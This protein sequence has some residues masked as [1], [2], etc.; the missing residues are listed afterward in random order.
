MT[1]IPADVWRREM[2]DARAALRWRF[3]DL[4]CLR[5]C[6]DR[7]LVRMW[8]DATLVPGV[9]SEVDNRVA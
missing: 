1:D 8:P 6:A 4:V 5:C 7:F 2:E 3:P 9:A